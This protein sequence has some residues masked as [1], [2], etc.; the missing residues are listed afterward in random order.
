[1]A[2][3]E[4]ATNLMDKL[5][6]VAAMGNRVGLAAA[7]GITDPSMA[8]VPLPAAWI[9]YEGDGIQY[10]SPQQGDIDY[11]FTVALMVSYVDQQDLLNIQ[12]PTLEALARSV[13]GQ[14]STDFAMRWQYQGAQL[15]DVFTDRLVYELK[16]MASASYS[17]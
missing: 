2:I 7:G 9:M 14:E 6:S 12:L 8:S 15:V 11:I 1:M 17:V 3:A 4:L 10:R 16:F 5:K 13:S